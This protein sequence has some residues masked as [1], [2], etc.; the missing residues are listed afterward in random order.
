MTQKHTIDFIKE[1]IEN[2]GHK[3]ISKRYQ[4]SHTNLQIESPDG[5]LFK[6]R[7]SNF[8]QGKR[9]PQRKGY[10]NRKYK[11]DFIRK[12]VRDEGFTL[13]SK[14]YKNAH[15]SLKMRCTH[16]H[17]FTKLWDDFYNRDATV[18]PECRRKGYI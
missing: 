12:T 17:V 6:M 9:C 7:W 18:C 11:I 5:E 8:Q 16:G 4:N 2:E 15:C 3:L 1:Q 13:L 10:S 14:R